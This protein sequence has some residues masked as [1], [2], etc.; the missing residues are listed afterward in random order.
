MIDNSAEAT[1]SH[2][3]LDLL[4]GANVVK[5]LVILP[6]VIPGLIV[7]AHNQVIGRWRRLHVLL[8]LG[9]PGGGHLLGAEHVGL[10][11]RKC[12]VGVQIIVYVLACVEGLTAVRVRVRLDTGYFRRYS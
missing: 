12:E 7:G 8:F 3:L 1:V 10:L 11:H 4:N 2:G 9:V 6:G 5:Q